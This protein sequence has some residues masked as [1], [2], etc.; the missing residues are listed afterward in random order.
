MRWLGSLAS[1]PFLYMLYLCLFHRA[2]RVV[3]ESGFGAH[4][5]LEATGTSPAQ[6]LT[7]TCMSTGR[8]PACGQLGGGARSPGKQRAEQGR[9]CWIPEV[10]DSP[11]QPGT[12][13]LRASLLRNPSIWGVSSP[14]G[15]AS[16]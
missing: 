8:G 13:W 6:T 3:A 12:P 1:L 10:E 9:A 11:L 5:H 14:K 2:P 15:R 7:A 4:E 16:H